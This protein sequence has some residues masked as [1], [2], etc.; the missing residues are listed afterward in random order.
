MIEDL[1]NERL[2]HFGFSETQIER[3]FSW[4]N[5]SCTV[6][7]NHGYVWASNIEKKIY[8]GKE[9]REKHFSKSILP[10]HHKEPKE[11]FETFEELFR[12]AVTLKPCK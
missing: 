4:E 2:I 7:G 6:I 3:L 9:G 8:S 5:Y 12:Y 11:K 10:E 1:T